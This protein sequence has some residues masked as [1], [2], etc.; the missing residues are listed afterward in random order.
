MYVDTVFPVQLF[1]TPLDTFLRF[2]YAETQVN[3]FTRAGAE[4]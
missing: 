3:Q 4:R 1:D 2:Q